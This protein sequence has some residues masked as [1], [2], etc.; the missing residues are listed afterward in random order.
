MHPPFSRKP[1]PTYNQHGTVTDVKPFAECRCIMVMPSL[2]GKTILC[3]VRKAREENTRSKKGREI[4]LV[5]HASRTVLGRRGRLHQKKNAVEGRED[6]RK[7]TTLEHK[8][9]KDPKNSRTGAAV[10]W[11][12]RTIPATAR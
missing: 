10:P 1:T 4:V 12:R 8:A 7:V 6:Q 9:A 3:K 5:V 2:V 11:A